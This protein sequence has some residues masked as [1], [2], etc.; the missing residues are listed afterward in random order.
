MNRKF[1]NIGS[2][3]GYNILRVDFEGPEFFFDLEEDESNLG[4]SLF[5]ALKYSHFITLEES[6]HMGMDKK[7]YPNWIKRT[8]KQYGHKTKGDMFKPMF[9]CGVS[10]EKDNFLFSPTHQCALN[11]WEGTKETEANKFTIPLTATAA[12]MGAALRRCLGLCTSK[13]DPPKDV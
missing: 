6:T 11:S 1:V 12:E 5:S 2:Y 8:M 3:I 9:S 13:F 10:E 7:S 4:L